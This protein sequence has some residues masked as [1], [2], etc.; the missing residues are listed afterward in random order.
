MSAAWVSVPVQLWRGE[1]RVQGL[2]LRRPLVTATQTLVF[3]AIYA[4]V[5]V[6]VRD[7][8]MSS[9]PVHTLNIAVL[10]LSLGLLMAANVT[11]V[12]E[13]TGTL[14]WQLQQWAASLPLGS[15][16][17]ARL[18]VAFSTLKS[19]LVTLTLLAAVAVGAL[20]A[21]HSLTS[22]AII[23]ASAVLLPLLPV[24]LGLQWARRRGASVSLAFSL[25]PLGV[26]VGAVAVPLPLTSGWTETAVGL[27]ALP[28]LLIA[29]RASFGEAVVFLAAWTGLA[30]VLLRPAALS[31][32]DSL[33]SRGVGSS[34][35]R[36]TRIPDSPSMARLALDLAIHKVGLTDLLE[37]LFL[38]TVSCSVVAL[39]T[40]ARDSMFGGLAMAGAFSAA[41]AT[42][43]IAGYVHMKSTVR[44]DPD[45]EAWVGT[46][47]ISARALSVASHAVCTGGAL[48]AVVPVMV[49]AIVKSGWP[50]EHGALILALWTGMSV[51][52]LT[53][54]FALYLS[55]QGWP[56]QL[57]GYLLFGWY[58][59]RAVA[60]AA[61]LVVSGN[62]FL[63][64]GLFAVDIGI[65][66][67][68]QWRG[69]IA[70]SQGRGQ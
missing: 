58:S 29:G 41:G 13:R 33:V 7:A 47:P 40:F 8:L 9:G 69:A 19:G 68:G 50:P 11:L 35:G 56:R 25:V 3:L 27:I 67:I 24:A 15:S 30:L 63:V 38:G 51:V 28:G 20:T 49:L 54:W 55:M 17:V 22:V 65:A 59:V 43:T 36:L 42:A 23:L 32:P 16:Q 12:G 34:I 10:T 37:I 62:P 6:R 44:M 64:A 66:L 21:A 2:L 48:L 52:A 26:G 31:L 53:G 60:G 14:P 61:I 57:A 70:A 1:L 18:I 39:Q 5:V 45:T 46:L 4:S